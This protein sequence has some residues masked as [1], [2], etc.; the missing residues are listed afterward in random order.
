MTVTGEPTV[1]R[2]PA[3]ALDRRLSVAPMMDW[4]DRHCRYFL[5]LIARRAL[6]YTEMIGAAA[7]VHGPRA[8]LLR[9]DPAE[10]PVALQLGGAEPEELAQ[11][12]AFGAAA[13]YDEINLNVGCPSERVQSA[14]FGACLMAEP[15]RVAACVQAM[16]ASVALPVTVKTR[17]GIDQRTTTSSSM[18]SSRRS[19]RRAAGRSSCMR[20]RPGSPG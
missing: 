17:I 1:G 11:A 4:T 6:L 9:F 12:A 14:R 19:R 16:Q 8:R 7:L 18:G 2:G 20:A 15:A 3:R 10:R 13:G 5:R